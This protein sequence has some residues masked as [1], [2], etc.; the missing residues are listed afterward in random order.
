M[1]KKVIVGMSGGVDSSVAAYIL[2]NKGYEVIGVTMKIWQNDDGDENGCYAE[3]AINDAKIVC[4]TLGIAHE[5]VDFKNSFKCKVIDYFIE[6]Y[7]DGRTPNPCIVC[8]SSVKWVGLSE[9]ASQIGADFIATG[10]YARIIKNQSG[11][12]TLQKSATK[13]K[14]QTYALYRLTQEQLSKTLMPVGDFTKDEIREMAKNINLKIAE[15]KDSQEIC[16]IPDHDYG[17]FIRENTDRKI[18]GGNFVD[19]DGNVLGKHKGISFYTIGQRKGLGM[20]FAQPMYVKKINPETGDVTLTTDDDLFTKKLIIKDVNF[21]GLEN[22]LKEEK[23]LGKIR[24][25]HKESLCKIK[26]SGDFLECE[27]E[28]PQRAVTPGQAAVF[29]EDDRILCG[30][31]IVI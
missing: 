16:F 22:L 21:M 19:I 10:H 6:E 8:N 2:K 28:E 27:F 4:E 13:A 20:S 18:V 25:A 1:N 7:L 3:S 14:D 29:Y 31:T 30:G 15:K 24:Y 26:M 11:R 9:K 17:K 5:V 23:V 12:F